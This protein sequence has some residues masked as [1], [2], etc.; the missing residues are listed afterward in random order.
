MIFQHARFQIWS[1][2]QHPWKHSTNGL[3]YSNPALPPSITNL[4]SALDYIVAV[5]YPQTKPS[6]ANPAALPL[7]GNSIN[8]YRVVLDDGDGK[9]AQH[10]WEQREGEGAASWHKV[11]D[12]DFGVDSILQQWNQDT[13][14]RYVSKYGHNDLDANGNE[15]VGDD[16]GQHIYGGIN[17]TGNLILNANAGDGVGAQTG[18][19]FAR[20]NVAPYITSIYSLGTPAKWF[21]KGYFSTEVNIGNVTIFGSGS[22]SCSTGQ[23]DFGALNLLTTGTVTVSTMDISGGNIFDSTGSIDFNTNNLTGIG[24]IGAANII[25]TAAVSTLKSGSNI[26]TTTFTDGNIVSSSGALAF[27]ANNLSTTGSLTGSSLFTNSVSISTNVISA[28]TLA[29]NLDLTATGDV[30][31]LKKFYGNLGAEFTGGDVIINAAKLQVS[32]VGSEFTCDELKIDGKTLSSTVGELWI[33]PLSTNLTM[34]GTGIYPFLNNGNDLGKSGNNWQKLWLGT[35]IGNASGQI[36][37]TDLLS[38]KS[39]PYRDTGRTILAVAGDSLFWSGTEW[40]ASAPDTEIAH[41]SLSGLTTGDSGHTQF[42]MLNGRVG[43]Q[44]IYGGTLAFQNLLLGSTFNAS[45]GAVFTMD[46]FFPLT[47]AA[48]DIG[49]VTGRFKDV[50]TSGQFYGLRLENVAA[51]PGFSAPTAGRLVFNTTDLDVYLDTGVAMKRL[52]HNSY[53]ADTSWNGT[54]TT[55]TVTVNDVDARFALWQLKDNTNNYEVIYCKIEALSSTSVRLTVTPA[56]PAGAYRLT[57]VE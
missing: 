29:T 4:S 13:L 38:L 20:S 47:D 24:Q 2:L 46:N 22:M 8:D 44:T 50:Y 25:A 26:G 7:V 1:A 34:F 15:Y 54:D 33:V 32:G 9:S 30:R 53:S 48:L 12:V 55:K 28:T 10:R 57:G 56:L 16:Y 43:S 41:N 17:A 6:V 19:I 11:G 23:F 18:Y 27:G 45:K 40:L 51:N 37:M 21:A 31:S 49:Q 14:H 35:A 42:V 36:T 3:V 52:N 5:L 39:T